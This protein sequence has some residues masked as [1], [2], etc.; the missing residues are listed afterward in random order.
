MLVY[1][2]FLLTLLSSAA[3]IAL[4]GVSLHKPGFRFWPPP[5]RESW[6]FTVFWWL[7]RAMIAGLVLLCIVDFQ[8][9]G[10]VSLGYH[11]I[12]I[13]L[14]LIGFGVAFHASFRLGWR[15]A[16]GER[17]GLVTD[18]WYRWSRNPI[19]VASWAGM[20]GLALTVHSA[21]V[22]VIL[23]LWAL[24]YAV[25]PFLEE[26]WLEQ[27]YGADYRRYKTGVSRFIGRS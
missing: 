18:G 25:A 22:D 2:I 4:G 3:I 17:Q 10:R 20:L 11:L 1:L 26:P 7:F 6:Q 9:L 16:H 13:P 24:M 5:S 21:H 27:E 23:V 12:G 14:T 15:N 19:Y 8:G